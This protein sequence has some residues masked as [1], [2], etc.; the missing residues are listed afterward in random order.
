MDRYEYMRMKLTDFPMHVQQKYNLQAH[1][2]NGYVYLEIRR[3]IY[4]LSKAGN[5]ENKYLREKLRPH[6][7]YRV[8]HTP[9]LWKNI[10]LPIDFSIVVDNFGVNYGGEDNARHLIDRLK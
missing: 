5:S 6:R 4:G 8:S 2:K 3:S 10:S 7:Y 1:D 9:G